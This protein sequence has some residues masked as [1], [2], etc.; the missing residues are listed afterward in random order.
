M[1]RISNKVF[2][3]N[4]QR[5]LR[6]VKLYIDANCHQQIWESLIRRELSPIILEVFRGSFEFINRSVADFFHLNCARFGDFL[7][8]TASVQLIFDY[9]SLTKT[10]FL[11]FIQT[12][13]SNQNCNKNLISSLGV[14]AH[15]FLW[16]LAIWRSATIFFTSS[17]SGDLS[18]SRA[19][20]WSRSSET[21]DWIL[22]CQKQT[23]VDGEIVGDRQRSFSLLQDFS[24]S[25]QW[26]SSSI[27][28]GRALERDLLKLNLEL[29]FFNNKLGILIVNSSTIIFRR[30]S[31]WLDAQAWARLRTFDQSR[32]D[33]IFSWN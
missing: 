10:S 4:F 3:R 22:F 11:N 2:Y 13:K 16:R 28:R 15:I 29:I 20:T 30:R 19:C 1:Y 18:G 23:L 14:R 7:I 32:F 5:E 12:N 27:D 17:I 31:S 8:W 26:C 24:S 21:F 6:M 9:T 25:V 33:E